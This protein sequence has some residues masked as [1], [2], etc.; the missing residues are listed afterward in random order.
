MPTLDVCWE[1]LAPGERTDKVAAARERFV[2]REI[3]AE[4]LP[5][6]R[7]AFQRGWAALNEVFGPV[8]EIEAADVLWRWLTAP[9]IPEDA[10]RVARYRMVLAY[11]RDG[12][13]AGVRDH[14]VVL[15]RSTGRVLIL[16]SHSLVL[17]N[18]RRTGLGALLRAAPL[19]SARRLLDGWR[20]TPAEVLL[21]AEMEPIDPAR[22]DQVVRMFAYAEAGFGVVPP[23]V[24]PYAQPD[25]RRLDLPEYPPVPLMVLIRQVGEEHRTD[26]PL[27]RI[28]A[29][30][31]LIHVVHG[32]ECP[33]GHLR[34]IR[35]HTDAAIASKA[36]DPQPLVR[37]PRG[38][39]QIERLRPLLRSA[40]L[41]SYPPAWYEGPLGDPDEDL[42]RL[43]AAWPPEMTS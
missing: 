40:A 28:Q 11:D 4:A 18:A 24:L 34:P 29:I 42:A 10:L 43:R 25:F 5:A 20:V 22:R 2:L 41:R 12:Q 30:V 23:D 13:L 7:A 19:A 6:D 8:G 37:L 36:T 3:G 17:Q 21:I 16:M 32:A 31:P 15:D 9:N 1:D 33:P 14:F 26:A 27:A 39:A 35:A 38:P